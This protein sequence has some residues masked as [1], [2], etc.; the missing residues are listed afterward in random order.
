MP[1]P[2]DRPRAPDA[3]DQTPRGND[4]DRP[5]AQ[6]VDRSGGGDSP[7]AADR[8]Q[9]QD[10]GSPTADDRRMRQALESFPPGHPSSPYLADGRRRPPEPNLRSMRDYEFKPPPE[11]AAEYSYTSYRD[12]GSDYESW[13]DRDGGDDVRGESRADRGR[14]DDVRTESRVESETKGEGGAGDRREYGTAEGRLDDGAV[15]DG[16]EYRE[17]ERRE[18]VRYPDERR[19]AGASSGRAESRRPENVGRD[20]GSGSYDTPR[21]PE[22]KH[23][24]YWTEVP[25]FMRMWGEHEDRW[26]MHEQPAA[27]VDRSRD[28]DGSWRSDSNLFLSP[29]AHART[30]DA[31]NDVHKAEKPTTEQIHKIGHQNPYNGR[32]VGLD[33]RL[34]GDDRL[35]E[36]VAET[37]RDNPGATPSEVVPAVPDAIRYTFCLDSKS[38][39]AGYWDIKRRLEESGYRMYSSRNSWEAAEYKGINTRWITPQ[40][41]RF[42]IQFHTRESHHA[43]Q[44]VTHKAYERIRNPLTSR[45]EIKKLRAFQREVSSWIP[46]PEGATGIPDYKREGF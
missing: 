20:D 11:Y 7:G 44:E 13:S 16:R 17:G 41:Q 32:L 37:L 42:E 3:P 38:Y 36:K 31:I 21:D 40:N 46:V 2:R 33:F 45:S 23:F 35:K 29:D 9:R 8:V 39:T 18:D 24:S 4:R 19:P 30:K 43:K 28:P 27:R 26:P 1:G 14:G 15:V 6:S 12:D 5:A 34:K 22:D 10:R 25:R